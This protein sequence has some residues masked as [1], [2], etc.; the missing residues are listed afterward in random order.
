MKDSNYSP[1]N[2][3]IKEENDEMIY[4]SASNRVHVKMTTNGKYSSFS[5]N[6]LLE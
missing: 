5:N 6:D 2:G 1:P 4:G 3:S